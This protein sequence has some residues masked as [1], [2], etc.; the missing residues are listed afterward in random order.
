MKKED[1]ILGMRVE[2]TSEE[3]DKGYVGR[4]VRLAID[5]MLVVVDLEDEGFLLVS[6]DDLVDPDAQ[7]VVA[8]RQ[9]FDA[10][11]S[12][13]AVMRIAVLNEIHLGGYL[14]DADVRT[15]DF[16]EQTFKDYEFVN[17]VFE[18]CSF[19]GCHFANCT[20][21]IVSFNYCNLAGCSFDDNCKF[22]A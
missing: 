19:A 4:I 14:L 20:F 9:L 22:I 1:C 16:K 11:V 21:D 18:Y 5:H 15:V 3:I 17:C 2:I 12:E 10:T 7:V 6:P 8:D 13:N